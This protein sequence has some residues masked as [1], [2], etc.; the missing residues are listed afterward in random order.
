MLSLELGTL[1]L[2]YGFALAASTLVDSLWREFFKFVL[3]R[4][5]W[6]LGELLQLP[7]K[8]VVRSYRPF[9]PL[10]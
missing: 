9:R 2:A 1:Q 8:G 4:W 10:P 5:R 7:K 6:R 3:A